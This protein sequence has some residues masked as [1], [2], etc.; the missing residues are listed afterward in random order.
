MVN[1]WGEILIGVGSRK[2]WRGRLKE[3]ETIERNLSGEFAATGSRAMDKGNNCK[4]YGIK[5]GY[6]IKKSVVTGVGR[7]PL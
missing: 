7:M 4:G 2:T 6:G 1:G 5:R 3:N